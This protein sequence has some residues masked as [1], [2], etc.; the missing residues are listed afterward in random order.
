[1]RRALVALGV[2]AAADVAASFEPNDWAA[3][4]LRSD[5]ISGSG[6]LETRYREDRQSLVARVTGRESGTLGAA[7]RCAARC[8]KLLRSPGYASRRLPAT[9]PFG[10]RLIR[11]QDGYVVQSGVAE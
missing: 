7:L 6:R 5:G 9:P 3:F 2:A 1:M 8:A 11:Q 4:R 10:L